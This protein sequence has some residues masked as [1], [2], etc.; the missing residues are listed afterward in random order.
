MT[1]GARTRGCLGVVLDGRCRDLNEHRQVGFPVFSRGLST[2]GQGGFTR[3]SELNVP[4]TISGAF[5]EALGPVT[6]HPGDIVVAD[7]DGVVCVPKEM[8]EDVAERCER[9]REID[10]KCLAGIQAGKGI[11]ETFKLH[12]G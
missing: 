8:V 2:L 4:L 5:D 7:A 1:A 10:E 3:P 6:V 12:R 11:A 9:G